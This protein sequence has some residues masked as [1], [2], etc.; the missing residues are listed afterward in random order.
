[1][2]YAPR[3]QVQHY[4]YLVLQFRRIQDGKRRNAHAGMVAQIQDLKINEAKAMRD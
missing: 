4:N 1:M 2:K 3:V